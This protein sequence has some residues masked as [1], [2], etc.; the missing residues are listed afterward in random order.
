MQSQQHINWIFCNNYYSK[1]VKCMLIVIYNM[2]ILSSNQSEKVCYNIFIYWQ[3]CLFSFCFKWWLRACLVS[4]FKNYFLFLKK[5]TKNV[6]GKVGDF[7]FLCF[8]CSQK[9]SSRRTKKKYIY[10]DCFFTIQKRVVLCV[11]F[12]CFLCFPHMASHPWFFEGQGPRW[13]GVVL[14]GFWRGCERCCGV[15]SEGVGYV[16]GFLARMWVVL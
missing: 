3:F 9:A 6:F 15:F 5:N 13:K 10:F 8:L 11:F 4:I 14:W 16:V 7:C 1:D 2:L 12:S